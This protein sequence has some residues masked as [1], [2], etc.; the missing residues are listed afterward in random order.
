VNV[1]E[2]LIREVPQLNE[3]I[4]AV[5]CHHER[6]DGSGYPRGLAGEEIP[7]IGRVIALADSYSAMRLDR[8]YRKGMGHDRV[9]NELV[10]GAGRQF[11]PDILK[12]FVELLLEEELLRGSSS[13]NRRAA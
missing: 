8:P 6:F 5:A 9:L 4:Q 3:V 11:D 12:I 10:A 13:S 1:G 7:L 2:V